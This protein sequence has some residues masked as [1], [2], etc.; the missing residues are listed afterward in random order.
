MKTSDEL[1]RE[2][3]ESAMAPRE[4]LSTAEWADK[5]RQVVVSSRRG[6]WSTARTP[7]LRGVMDAIDDPMVREVTL[8]SARQMGKTEV[9]INVA[10]RTVDLAPQD[11]LWAYPTKEVAQFNNR[12]RFIPTFRR[13]PRLKRWFGKSPRDAGAMVLN[14]RRM[15]VRFVGSNSEANLESYP[16]GMVIIDELDRCDPMVIDQARETVKTFPESKIIK[17]S[18]PSFAGVGIDAEYNGTQV[19]TDDGG[20]QEGSGYAGTP[21]SDRRRYC[22]PCPHCGMFHVRMWN[23]VRWEGGKTASRAFVKAHAHM[24]CPGCEKRIEAKDNLWQLERG[25]WAPVGSKAGGGSGSGGGGGVIAPRRLVWDGCKADGSGTKA[26]EASEVRGGDY[27]DPDVLRYGEHVGFH[28]GGL[29]SSMEANPYGSVA[30]KWMKNGCVMTRAFCNRVL[31]DAWVVKGEAV[32][33]REIV[34]RA[35]G[36]DVGEVV[37]QALRITVGVDVQQDRMYAEVLAWGAKG[38]RCWFVECHEIPRVRGANLVELEALAKKVWTRKDGKRLRVSVMAVDSGRYTDEVYRFVQRWRPGLAIGEG[39]SK[40][41]A[42]KGEPGGKSPLPW[43]ETA[44][45]AREDRAAS[46]VGE[47]LPLLLVNTSYWKEHTLA[48]LAGRGDA[49]GEMAEAVDE[50]HFPIGVPRGYLLQL[51]AEQQVVER[52]GASVVRSWVIRPGRTANHYLDCR[53]YGCAAA[54]REGI[55]RLE[56]AAAG[57]ASRGG[58]AAWPGDRAP[59]GGVRGRGSS[60]AARARERHG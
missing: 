31:G 40:V 19:S 14:F 36:Y 15:F 26:T 9:I 49:S 21:P 10:G 22:V 20:D 59:E 50:W 28:L 60:L 41:W 42:V 29:N 18:T 43:R 25:V 47:G 1:L 45:K 17:V 34:S 6:Q 52:R 57:A 37:E 4:K 53:V 11:M 16:Y 38:E 30:A 7:Y 5:Y 27:E 3:L 39:P 35:G 48:R 24:V 55:R 44:V 54:D 33:V 58:A 32:D 12:T 46:A 13:T 8:M 23:Q 51:T 2:V 56:A